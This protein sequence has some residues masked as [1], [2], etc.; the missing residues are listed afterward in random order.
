MT[1]RQIEA[2]TV[3]TSEA[4]ITSVGMGAIVIYASPEVGP[5]EVFVHLDV[6][7]VTLSARLTEREIKGRRFHCAVF[8]QVAGRGLVVYGP[9][10]EQPVTVDARPGR[11]TQLDWR[12]AIWTAWSLTEPDGAPA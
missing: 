1:I 9:S 2:P 10:R 7:N 6:T 12:R 8:P 4:Q 11:V 3:I 5:A